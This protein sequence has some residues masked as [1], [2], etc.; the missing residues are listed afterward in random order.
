MKEKLRESTDRSGSGGR[1]PLGS[2]GGSL[3][4]FHRTLSKNEDSRAS[5]SKCR[6]ED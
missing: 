6:A 3:S 2:G 5:F 4:S 1:E